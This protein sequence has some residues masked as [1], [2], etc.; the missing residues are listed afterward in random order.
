M[1][2]S[3]WHGIQKVG[4]PAVKVGQVVASAYGIST[5]PE[6]LI[7]LGAGLVLKHAVKKYPNWA[8]PAANVVIGTGV[9]LAQ[10][11]PAEVAIAKGVERAIYAAGA[12]SA[13]KSPVQATV[14]RSL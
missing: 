2:K 6:A 11:M 4:R 5:E 9:A 1:F 14:G 13:I 10:H 7:N 12:Q 8:I 3:I